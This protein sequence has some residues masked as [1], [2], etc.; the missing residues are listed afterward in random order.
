MLRFVG[1][2]GFIRIFPCRLW[3][4]WKVFHVAMQYP[5]DYL[6]LLCFWTNIDSWSYF[7]FWGCLDERNSF[8]YVVGAVCKIFR[9]AVLWNSKFRGW[10]SGKCWITEEDTEVGCITWIIYVSSMCVLRWGYL[11]LYYNLQVFF[12]TFLFLLI[13]T[14]LHLF[15]P[16]VW[17]RRSGKK[18]LCW[19]L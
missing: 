3:D 7:Q 2:F 8:V 6:V 19:F 10:R 4:L 11:S 12:F 15:V 13:C 18:K 9:P 5:H 17:L 14:I 16:S 1:L